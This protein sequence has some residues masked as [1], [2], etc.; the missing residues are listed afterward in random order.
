MENSY[1]MILN[2][3]DLNLVCNIFEIINLN[4][5]LHFKIMN[6]FYECK[7]NY[8]PQPFSFFILAYSIP[9]NYIFVP[10]IFALKSSS[11]T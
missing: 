9:Y 4:R 3:L 1:I 8:L 7:I 5:L 6:L 10:L 2:N 11:T